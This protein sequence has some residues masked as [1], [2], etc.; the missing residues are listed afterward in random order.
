MLIS[1]SSLV[2]L[3]QLVILGFLEVFFGFC[4]RCDGRMAKRQ[5]QA[6]FL[7]AQRFKRKSPV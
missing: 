7:A 6:R 5:Q 2:P 3:S 4:R 1:V